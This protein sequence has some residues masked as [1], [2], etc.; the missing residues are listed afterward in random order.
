MD[1]EDIF[2]KKAVQTLFNF[3]LVKYKINIKNKQP[4][5]GLLYNLLKNELAVLR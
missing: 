3:I 1:L 2:N 5:F 4:L